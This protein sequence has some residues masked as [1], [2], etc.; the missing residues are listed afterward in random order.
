MTLTR[1]IRVKIASWLTVVVIATIVGAVYSRMVYPEGSVNPGDWRV[2]AITGM[3][4][5]LVSIPLEIFSR[6]LPLMIWVRG[7]PGG[8]NWLVRSAMHFAIILLALLGTQYIFDVYHQSA[9]DFQH[10]FRRRNN[11]RRDLLRHRSGRRGVHPGDESGP[12][13]PGHCQHVARQLFRAIGE[14]PHLPA[15]RHG[16][17]ERGGDSNSATSVSMATCRTF[18]ASPKAASRKRAAKST[19]SSAMP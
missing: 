15:G 16:E 10:H 4:I 17:I 7:L 3:V 19:R 5:A 14:T 13:R 12:R 18:S 6:D 2:G 8:V 1:R 9:P 11:D